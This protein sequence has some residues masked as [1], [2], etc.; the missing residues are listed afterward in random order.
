MHLLP[1]NH[2]L[3]GKQLKSRHTPLISDIHNV[4]SS[5]FAHHRQRV[6]FD[7]LFLVLPF[8]RNER[9]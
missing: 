7:Q 8:R 6:R 1:L 9:S 5:G 3:L 2:L 4:L